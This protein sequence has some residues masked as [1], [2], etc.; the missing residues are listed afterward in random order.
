MPIRELCKWNV[1]LR[2]SSTCVGVRKT[3]EAQKGREGERERE[4]ER[5]KERERERRKWHK[6]NKEAWY[7]GI[8]RSAWALA[9]A[10]TLVFQVMHH[11]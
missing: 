1:W 2:N 4:R 8:M 5:E 9:V 6:H 10:L 3:R 11:K 7:S